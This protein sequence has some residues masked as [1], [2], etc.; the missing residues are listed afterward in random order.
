MQPVLSACACK[1]VECWQNL[2]TCEHA[3]RGL[4]GLRQL[5]QLLL[6]VDVPLGTLRVTHLPA[7]LSSL[8]P[9]C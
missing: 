2:H 1:L 8:A 6:I 3:P 4:V 7:S 5:C 9:S